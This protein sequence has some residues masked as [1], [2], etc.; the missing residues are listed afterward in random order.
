MTTRELAE[1]VWAMRS[2]Q[3]EYF[4]TRSPNALDRARAAEREVDEVVRRIL[5]GGRGLF[6]EGEEATS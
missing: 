4:R 2:A 1:M 5:Y 3:V 6:P